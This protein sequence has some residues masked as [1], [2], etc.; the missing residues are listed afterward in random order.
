M[1]VVFLKNVH[2]AGLSYIAHVRA[3]TQPVASLFSSKETKGTKET[4]NG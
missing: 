1:D 4:D 3:R 2:Q